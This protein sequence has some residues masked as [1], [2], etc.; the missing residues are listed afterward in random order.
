VRQSAFTSRWTCYLTYLIKVFFSLISL[1]VLSVGNIEE[2]EEHSQRLETSL[3]QAT[4]ALD[5]E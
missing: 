1:L 3:V 2:R 4:S 5:D